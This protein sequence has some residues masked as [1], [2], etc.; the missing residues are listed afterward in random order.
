MEQTHEQYQST[1]NPAL[2]AITCIKAISNKLNSEQRITFMAHDTVRSKNKELIHH[3][4][5]ILLVQ[6]IY[7]VAYLSY[8]IVIMISES[9]TQLSPHT[10][11]HLSLAFFARKR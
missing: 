11:T 2:I 1:L 5:I 3:N 8:A 7:F 6:V 9:K 10:V 4:T